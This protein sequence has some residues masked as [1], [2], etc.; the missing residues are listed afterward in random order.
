MSYK[1]VLC[2]LL[3]SFFPFSV[4][5][6]SPPGDV[7]DIVQ[8]DTLKPGSPYNKIWQPYIATWTDKHYVVSYGRQLRGKVDM[9]DVVCSISKDKGKTWSPSI[10]IFNHRVPNGTVQYAYNNSVLFRPQGQ[11]ILWCFAMRCPQDYRDSEDSQLCAAYSGDG[12]YCWHAVELIMDFHSPLITNAGIVPV[13]QNGVTRYLLPVHRNTKRHDPLGDRQQFVLE[14]RS[15]LR[16]KLAG[17]IPMPD[18]GPIFQHEGN[19]APGDGDGELKIVMRT[20]TYAKGGAALDPPRAFS[21]VSTDGG[22]TWSPSVQEPALYNSVAK[23][24]FGKDSKGWHIYVY[25]DGPAWARRGLYY[26]TKSAPGDWSQPRLFYHENN[27]NSYPTLIEEEAGEFLCVWDSSNDP[28][29]RRT[30]IRFGRLSLN[31]Q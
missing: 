26:V 24:Y 28:K 10:M 17:Y 13:T 31:R 20:A 5:H 15:L 4:S 19:I 21:S 8:I 27:R 3:A 16:W 7:T 29:N 14:S 1:A 18:S 25:N 2:F 9:G 11:D 12:G 30:S 6:A 23:G 22:R